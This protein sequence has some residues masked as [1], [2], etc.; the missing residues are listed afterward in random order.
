MLPICEC[1]TFDE[2]IGD[3]CIMQLWCDDIF[4]LFWMNYGDVGFVPIWMSDDV[5]L[6]CVVLL[7]SHIHCISEEG[8]YAKRRGFYA[9]RWWLLCRAKIGFMPS[10]PNYGQSDGYHMH[11]IVVSHGV[12]CVYVWVV[13]RWV[14]LIDEW[15]WIAMIYDMM[16]F[17]MMFAMM[18]WCWALC[19]NAKMG[20][21]PKSEDDLL[22]CLYY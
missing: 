11:N 7:S 15:Y 22:C 16:L 8:F 4:I 6:C 3:V 17:M 14:L 1:M 5:V 18:L 12:G 19:Q 9:K 2:F 21:M 10:V 13:W 20:F